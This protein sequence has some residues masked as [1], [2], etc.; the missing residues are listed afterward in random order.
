MENTHGMLL[1][2]DLQDGPINKGP[3]DYISLGRN[4]LDGLAALE[5]A[6]EGGEVLELDEVPNIRE[7]GLD[8]GGLGDRGGSWDSARHFDDDDST[9]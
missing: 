7:L 2:L 4:T 8:D 9:F 3:L 1:L 5:L 6:P